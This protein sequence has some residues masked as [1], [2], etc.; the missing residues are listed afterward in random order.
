MSKINLV[1]DKDLIQYVNNNRSKTLLVDYGYINNKFYFMVD[2]LSQKKD[3]RKMLKNDLNVEEWD[4]NVAY[5]EDIIDCEYCNNIMFFTSYADYINL[6]DHYVCKNC[7]TEDIKQDYLEFLSKEMYI[8]RFLSLD[9]LLSNN[10]KLHSNI[11]IEHGKNMY[12]N[13]IQQ[14]HYK[15][16][17]QFKDI[18][19]CYK[20]HDNTQTTYNIYTR[21]RI[22]NF[23]DVFN[24]KRLLYNCKY[25]QFYDTDLH[26]PNNTSKTAI[27]S[28]L[29]DCNSGTYIPKL[30]CD[31]FCI[32]ECEN[33]DDENYYEIFKEV[34][35]ELTTKI[36]EYIQFENY[37][38]YF[39]Y[40]EDGDYCLFASYDTNK[41]KE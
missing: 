19:F 36:N 17:K 41:D 25:L 9:Y 2:T 20:E 40:N 22:I 18:I 15:L 7:I 5:N 24:K 3:L 14:E 34:E 21:D 6:G 33:V 1:K 31:M 32:Q 38:F 11:N 8:D 16:S 10:F 13:I 23:D 12:N 26:D 27:V 37:Y 35:N 39:D 29:V 4:Y 28:I 30:V